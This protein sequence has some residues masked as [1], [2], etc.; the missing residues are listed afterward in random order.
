MQPFVFFA[1]VCMH[2]LH[3]TIIHCLYVKEEFLLV[4]RVLCICVHVYDCASGCLSIHT[5]NS[6]KT[7][8]RQPEATSINRYL[9]FEL[10]CTPLVKLQIIIR[11]A[12]ERSNCDVCVYSPKT[13]FFCVCVQRCHGQRYGGLN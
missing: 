7:T 6:L 1:Y 2:I 12:S 10:A 5:W 8:D 9:D 13:V 4:W 11:F 3:M